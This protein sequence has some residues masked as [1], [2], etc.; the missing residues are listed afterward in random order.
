MDIFSAGCVLIELFTDGTPPFSFS[1]LLSY[2][3]GE[4]DPVKCLDK[5]EDEDIKRLLETMI[6]K[7]PSSRKTA[8]EHLLEQR[9]KGFPDYFYTF[10]QSY[11]QIFSTDPNMLPDAKIA[12]IHENLETLLNKVAR[13]E[14]DAQ[15]LTLI[16]KTSP[17][18]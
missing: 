13:D 8:N 2:Q 9:G 4:F 16:G 6:K 18:T 3:A 10:L 12:K 15:G 5:I 14:F 7:D 1:Q 17:R 11:M